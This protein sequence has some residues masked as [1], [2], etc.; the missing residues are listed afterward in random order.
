MESIFGIL[1]YLIVYIFEFIKFFLI[2]KYMLGW[3]QKKW[4]WKRWIV[5][6]SGFLGIAFFFSC[7][8]QKINPLLFYILFL[9]IETLPMFEEV[10]W[11]M[12]FVTFIE[13]YAI[14][15]IDAMGLQMH[16][17][18]LK[19][20]NW[21]VGLPMDLFVSATTILFLLVVIY[22]MG[23]KMWGTVRKIS[24]RYY[25]IF[26]M[27]ATG[28]SVLLAEFQRIMK[29]GTIQLRIT[30]IFIVLGIFLE[31]ALLL[32]LAATREVYKEKDLLNQ[33]YLKWQERHY[34]Y[35]EQRETATKKFR[36][37]MRNHIYIFQ[38]LLEQGKQEEAKLYA[39]ELEQHFTAMGTPISVNHGIV[40]AIL[41]KYAAECEEKKIS[42]SI[43]GYMPKECGVS[44][45]DLC[46][47][48]SN[49]L[50]NA[51]EATEKC[52]DKK[53][54]L[55]LRHEE[56]LFM[57][58]IRNTFDGKLIEKNGNIQTGKKDK[59]MH[60]YG[61]LNVKD[62]VERN[63]GHMTIQHKEHEFVVTILL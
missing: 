16:T 29:D 45:F 48:F 5:A 50:S 57:L 54:W 17:V 27:L 20:L 13:I 34:K 25:V 32:V 63:Q 52:N 8:S 6:G 12:I 56:G 19:L 55:Y 1:Y 14:S 9:M 40:D 4:N 62:C 36:H 30:F 24:A 41:N 35:L 15:M 33:K 49:V 37:D 43:K 22:A 3:Q 46:V 18:L 53:I 39:S 42:L 10:L 61:L 31:L 21:D 38:H 60:G 23:Y 58:C 7:G 59:E 47:I 26:I 11:K 44:S 51:V 2:N 28:N